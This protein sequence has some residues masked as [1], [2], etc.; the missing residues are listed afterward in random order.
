MMVERN[1]IAFLQDHFEGTFQ[2][3]RFFFICK[4]HIKVGTFLY[5]S[6]PFKMSLDQTHVRH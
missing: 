1:P 6:Y 2:M 3:K 5:R 4:L